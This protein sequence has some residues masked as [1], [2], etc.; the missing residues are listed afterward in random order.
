[1]VA[2]I[3]GAQWY[4]DMAGRCF[5]AAAAGAVV[6]PDRSLS[7]LLSRCAIRARL[8]LAACLLA[9][10]RIMA[11]RACARSI[12]RGVVAGASEEYEQQRD[13]FLAHLDLLH[14]SF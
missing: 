8:G 6:R 4:L 12:K 1:M 13:A 5:Q 10:G 14:A 9:K 11:A 3:F 7:S 2:G